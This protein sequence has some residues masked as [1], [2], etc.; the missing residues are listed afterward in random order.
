MVQ[1]TSYL[2]NDSLYNKYSIKFP[3][4]IE[5]ED[6]G[7]KKVM[8]PNC[9]K[10]IKKNTCL[11][12]EQNIAFKTG[13]QNDLSVLDFDCNESIQWFEENFG[14]KDSLN[15]SI[16]KTF[17]G[18]HLYFKYT[19]DFENLIRDKIVKSVKMEKNIDY[20]GDKGIIFYG[21]GYELLKFEENPDTIPEEF[22]KYFEN[23]HTLNSIDNTLK[24]FSLIEVEDV[25]FLLDNINES[26]FDNYEDWRNIGFILK[27]YG[28]ETSYDFKEIF[29]EFSKSKCNEKFDKN[30]NENFWDNININNEKKIGLGSLFFYLMKDNVEIYTEFKSNLVKK[31]MKLKYQNECQE[32]EIEYEN[33]EDLYNLIGKLTTK[34]EVEL[35]IL[36]KCFYIYNKG[37]GFFALKNLHK[38]GYLEYSKVRDFPIKEHFFYKGDDGKTFRGCFFEIAN[39][40]KENK[41]FRK[42]GLFFR[43]FS[44]KY[45]PKSINEKGDR[46]LNT[47]TGFKYK[48][49]K[50]FVVDMKL[51]E[52]VLHHF[53]EVICGGR[54]DKLHYYTSWN[55]NI[56]Q[57]GD[58]NNV[59]IVLISEEQ[60]TGKGL[61]TGFHGDIL[62][63]YYKPLRNEGELFSRF[64]GILEDKLL[65]KIDE[66][67]KGG[68]LY[69][70]KDTFKDIIDRT[71][72]TIENK[73]MDP[74]ETDDFCNYVVHSN[75]TDII[76][77][78]GTDRRFAFFKVSD[79]YLGNIEYFDKLRNAMNDE[80]VKLH[81]FHYLMNYDISKFNSQNIIQ[82]ELKISSKLDSCNSILKFY[83][84]VLQ[85]IEIEDKMVKIQTSSFYDNYKKYIVEFENGRPY[86]KNKFLKY[87]K[88][89]FLISKEVFIKGY[90]YFYFS[91]KDILEKI[92]KILKLKEEDIPHTYDEG[93][94]NIFP[95]HFRNKIDF[96]EED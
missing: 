20:R 21:E 72:M 88:D 6:N 58:K 33:F 74:Y 37:K 78:E 34:E 25:R 87:I 32:L 96:I 73:G 56:F 7:K 64:N 35:L 14:D 15:C 67:R 71:R 46:Y 84:G 53:K 62:G 79:K 12:N 70:N 16:V 5:R 31:N 24:S 40:L 9:W 17:K 86:G 43:P 36:N 60:G 38:G 83:F 30:Y 11:G 65:I 13:K 76:F 29:M 3:V 63:R 47:F 89:H 50:D 39:C 48:Y 55:A 45:I 81:Y 90:K 8:F 68:D 23:R 93:V 69:D 77:V 49:D 94:A 92:C 42:V 80:N 28:E 4:Q 41:D 22:I 91:K 26:R 44:E 59:V 1:R 82:E 10:N 57:K 54:E 2:K 61:A 27:N 52:P 19:Q 18:F 95:Y 85:S 51:I 66:I 75:G